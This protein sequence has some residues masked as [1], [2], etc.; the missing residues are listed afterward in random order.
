MDKFWD[1]TRG[2][3]CGILYV[4]QC[5]GKGQIS[6]EQ[7]HLSPWGFLYGDEQ[8][9]SPFCLPSTN[10]LCSLYTVLLKTNG[11]LGEIAQESTTRLLHTQ[12]LFHAVV[13]SYSGGF[14]FLLGQTIEARE[15]YY[16]GSLPLCAWKSDQ[17]WALTEHHYSVVDTLWEGNRGL[18]T[19]DMSLLHT[20][21]SST[22]SEGWCRV[23]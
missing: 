20:S 14:V 11:M 2:K 8:V 15:P 3:Y 23:M 16:E 13:W 1:K 12:G 19:R 21:C 17:H 5:V 18:T 10:W 7:M 9:L 6:L 4:C 22:L